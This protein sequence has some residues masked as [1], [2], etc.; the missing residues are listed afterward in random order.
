[1]GYQIS[2]SDDGRAMIETGIKVLGPRI[3]ASGMTADY[4]ARWVVFVSDWEK[5]K[6]AGLTGDVVTSYGERL[7]TW[8]NVVAAFNVETSD[9]KTPPSRDAKA[10]SGSLGWVKWA[11]LGAGGLGIYILLR[12]PP[13]RPESEHGKPGH[14]S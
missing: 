11:V 10:A 5:A 2:G 8:K 7:A 3:D 9:I 4:K 12:S 1:M 6:K 13:T 14:D